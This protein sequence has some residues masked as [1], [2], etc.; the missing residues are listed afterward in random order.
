M[1]KEFINKIKD[2]AIEIYKQGGNLLPSVT[3][4]QSILESGWGESLLSK[5]C[6]NYFGIKGDYNGQ[7]KLYSTQ[8][9]YGGKW[10]S[11]NS[12]FRKY[13]T[14]KEGLIDHDNLMNL[15]RYKLVR[16]ATSY[17]EQCR[18][19]QQCGYATNPNYANLLIQIIE[20]NNLQQ[21][22][23]KKFTTY[24]ENKKFKVIV[25]CLNVREYPS[26]NATIV[27]EYYKNEVFYSEGYCINEGYVWR[28]YI[29]KS[30]LR[31]Y[32]A[33]RTVDNKEIYT[34]TIE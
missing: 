2:S 17:K 3:I 9:C 22:D 21:Y 25:N 6:N 1:G 15:D 12:Y 24:K 18:Q 26:L 11:I 20:E 4:A 10:V 28:T 13:P 31:R 33:T 7:C 29:S 27:A 8:E 34:K 5:E 14:I 30:G 19:L 32:I 16:Q 23:S